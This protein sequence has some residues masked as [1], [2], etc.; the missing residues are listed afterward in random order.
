LR[1]LNRL[2]SGT[3]W[4]MDALNIR[5]AK[6]TDAPSIARIYNHYVANTVVTFEEEAVSDHAMA[7]R[8]ADIRGASLP[9]PGSVALH[10]KLG[11]RHLGTFHQVGYK[12]GRWVDVGYWEVVL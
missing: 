3:I 5:P 12:Q 10:E 4:S 8:I 7:G 9:N 1:Y 2:A 6:E 11:F